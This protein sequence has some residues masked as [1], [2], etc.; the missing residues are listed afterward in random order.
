MACSV[1]V[2]G[3]EMVTA[4]KLRTTFQY[5]G[6]IGRK[7]YERRVRERTSATVEQDNQRLVLN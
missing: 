3:L 1:R 2:L 6:R 4:P 7:L 5:G